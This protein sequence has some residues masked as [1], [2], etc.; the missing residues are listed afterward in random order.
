MMS[1]ET[2]DAHGRTYRDTYLYTVDILLGIQNKRS[3]SL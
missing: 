2:N 3:D 1:G